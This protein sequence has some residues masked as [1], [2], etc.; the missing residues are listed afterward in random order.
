MSVIDLFSDKSDMRRLDLSIPAACM[1]F[2]FM[3]QSGNGCGTVELEV[4]R[5]RS[6]SRN[7]FLFKRRMSAQQK[8]NAIP[9][10]NVHFTCST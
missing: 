10:T 7:I 8:A 4:D 6:P 2:S 9:E 1:S 5:Q 3:C